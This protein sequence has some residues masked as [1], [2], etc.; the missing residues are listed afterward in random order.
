MT[1][2]G[3]ACSWACSIFSR[4]CFVWIAY[5]L[6]LTPTAAVVGLAV[7]VGHNWPVFLRFHGAGHRRAG[8]GDNPPILND[9]PLAF[10]D[11]GGFHPAHD[12]YLRSSPLPVLISRQ[13]AVD[14]LAVRNRMRSSWPG[15]LSSGGGRQTPYAQPAPGL[16]SAGRLVVNRLFF[17]RDI[18]DRHAWVHR[19]HFDEKEILE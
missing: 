19:E 7:I 6:D 12:R 8:T 13:P 10:G 15:W 4:A 3:S 5:S 16:K 14:R 17:D 1:S 9:V 18:A 11:C 2:A